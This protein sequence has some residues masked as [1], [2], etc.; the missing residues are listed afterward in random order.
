MFGSLRHRLPRLGRAPRLCLAGACLLL[1]LLSATGAKHGPAPA[2]SVAVLVAARD[3]PAGHTLARSD[4]AVGRWPP[5]LRPAGRAP[6]RPRWLASGSRGRSGPASRSP[7]RGSSV[8]TS[9][10][11]WTP[12]RLP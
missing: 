7:R 10:P 2:P 5:D 11:G 3:L 12:A 1:A 8:A 9:P 4:V 6:R